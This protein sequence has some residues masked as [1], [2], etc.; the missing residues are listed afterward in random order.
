MLRKHGYRLLANTS[1]Q[2]SLCASHPWNDHQFVT[3]G[4]QRAFF[5]T[6]IPWL[7]TRCRSLPLPKSRRHR[8]EA[9]YDA[10]PLSSFGR[11]SRLRVLLLEVVLAHE[12]LFRTLPELR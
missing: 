2:H 11:T 7:E 3:N 6:C 8:H 1:P 10:A 4:D 5:L 12:R 9:A